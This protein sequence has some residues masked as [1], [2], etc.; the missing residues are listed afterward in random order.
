[1]EGHSSVVQD[2]T[3]TLKLAAGKS[4]QRRLLVISGDKDWCFD[5]VGI[6]IQQ[7]GDQKVLF[8][9][10]TDLSTT[11]EKVESSRASKL[12]KWLG[13]EH[14]NIVFDAFSGFDVDA[15]GAISGALSAGGVFILLT[16]P[17][18][19]WFQFPDPENR[20]IIVYPQ[21]ESAVSGW[22]L[23]RLSLLIQSSDQLSLWCQDGQLKMQQ[24]CSVPDSKKKS[25]PAPY[26][27][28]CQAKAVKA[29]HK[30]VRGHRRRPLVMTADRG[31]GKS[32]ALGIAAAQLLKEGIEQILITAPTRKT[33]DIFF[34][35]L[36]NELG[37]EYNE[38]LSRVDFIAPDD[39]VNS[40]PET[41][42]L[43]VDEAAAI[44]SP[45]LEVML[46]TYSRI[47]YAT[48]VHGYEGT[49]RGFAIRF[50]KTLDHQA[51]HWQEVRLEAPIRWTVGDSLESFVFSALLLN[52]TPVEIG[53]GKTVDPGQCQFRELTPESLIHDEALLHQLFGLLVL[54]HYQTRPFDLRQLLDG[55]NISIFCLFTPDNKLV[56]V[57]L[58][59]QE[60]E[61]ESTLSEGIWLG[62]RRVRGHLLPQ[63]LSNHL[64]LPHAITLSGMRV[65]RVA[66]HPDV[67]R[68]GLGLVLLHS[69]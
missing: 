54:A 6:A 9:G 60:G 39:L 35:H 37:E 18:G 44:P 25:P 32:A 29:I 33:A 42:L 49:G 57:L 17:L 62:Q 41:A 69:F 56:A 40:R 68:M 53:T 50:K 1:M 45:M 10:N 65:I 36:R 20:R 59:A 16:P 63:S 14:K 5:Q 19:S 4:G 27:T 34:Q 11:H 7:L 8:V 64:G 67:Q 52:A 51:P 61:I 2:M 46:T 24:Q 3:R 12:S 23:K 28:F 55:G 15:F 47:V 38:C 31:R 48:T 43:L 66:V 21:M 26:R 13:R 30:V 58:A 22:Y